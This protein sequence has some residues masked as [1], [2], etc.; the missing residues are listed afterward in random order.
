MRRSLIKIYQVA[1]C[2]ERASVENQYQSTFGPA[3]CYFSPGNIPEIV[4]QCAGLFILIRHYRV[5]F[6]PIKYFKNYLYI[7]NLKLF[8]FG[9]IV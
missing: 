7:I 5:Y 3:A 1:S 6:S 9:I 4:F 2:R 8:K